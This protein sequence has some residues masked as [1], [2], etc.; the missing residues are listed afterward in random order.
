MA[1]GDNL[2]DV[3]MLDFAGAAVVMGNSTDELKQRG[4]LITASNDEGG[5]AAAIRRYAL[6]ERPAGFQDSTSRLR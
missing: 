3:E 4:Y 2:N 5:V 6:N 1:I